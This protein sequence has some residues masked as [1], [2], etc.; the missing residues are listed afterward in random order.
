MEREMDNTRRVSYFLKLY[1]VR[2]KEKRFY[3]E[4]EWE[5]KI[6]YHLKGPIPLSLRLALRKVDFKVM[7]PVPN[8]LVL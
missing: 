7:F 6:L 4:Y 2:Y 8:S 1:T 5:K 3:S